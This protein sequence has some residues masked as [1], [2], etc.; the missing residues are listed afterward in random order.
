MSFDDDLKKAFERHSL[1][2]DPS[3]DA[4]ANI[5]T[6]VRRAQR[7]KVLLVG[8]V[9]AMALVAAVAI[10]PTLATSSVPEETFATD[11]PTPFPTPSPSV[12]PT[13]EPTVEET[14]QPTPEPAR[15]APP[16]RYVALV[17]GAIHLH[18]TVTGERLRVLLPRDDDVV[19][20]SPVVADDTVY[21]V[22]EPFQDRSGGCNTR[23]RAVSFDGEARTVARGSAV[24]FS[25]DGSTMAYV[26]VPDAPDCQKGGIVVVD[27]EAGSKRLWAW[28]EWDKAYVP[29]FT[30]VH[31]LAWHP[32]GRHLLFA[33]TVG[34]PG[35][36]H[37]LLDTTEGNDILDARR[38]N[39]SDEAARGADLSSAAFTADGS[40]FIVIEQ[41]HHEG[42]QPRSLWEI[43]VETGQKLDRLLRTDLQVE[44]L[45]VSRRGGWF[46]MASVRYPENDPGNEPVVYLWDGAGEPRVL[47]KGGQEVAW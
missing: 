16:E 34:D 10:V 5:E 1:E 21:F 6:N 46:L 25:Q 39:T 32:D 45:A 47:S 11:Q 31:S 36:E 23:I 38:L 22:E 35:V 2:R 26:S 20:R 4:W 43:D 18:S 19:R 41:I 3:P 17:N 33:I 7:R 15:A 27:L 29:E 13:P 14:P 24:A 37:F 30:A 8:A 12:E 42:E 9:S 28:R 40:R 44:D